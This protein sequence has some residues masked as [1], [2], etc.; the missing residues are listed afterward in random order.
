M[1]VHGEQA[2]TIL[3]SLLALMASPQ[4]LSRCFLVRFSL[5]RHALSSS[6]Q[7]SLVKSPPRPPLSRRNQPEE[8]ER[9]RERKLRGCRRHLLS[10]S[11]VWKLQDPWR[12]LPSM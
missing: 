11:L 9:L 2:D 4:S 7:I 12:L 3:A 8:E 1:F 5:V 6:H 10:F